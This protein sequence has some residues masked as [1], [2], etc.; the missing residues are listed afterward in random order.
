MA[1]IVA[2]P[3]MIGIES[4]AIVVGIIK[5]VGCLTMT[6]FS[7][8]GEKHKKIETLAYSTLNRISDIVSKALNDAIISDEEYS[9]I[10]LKLYIFTQ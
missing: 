10:L 3:V 9:H 4:L 2:V 5:V 8:K 7:I 1:T 6:K